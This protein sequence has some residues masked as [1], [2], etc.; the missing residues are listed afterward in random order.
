M[1][2]EAH[3]IFVSYASPDR[4]RVLPI[5]DWLEQQ[6]LN[7]WMDAKRLMPGQNWDF[8][9]NRA[10]D[11]SCIILIFISSNSIDRRGY[12][13]KE[14]RAALDKAKEKLIDDIYI[15]PIIIDIDLD[16]PEQLRHIQCIRISE[17]DYKNV[18]YKS[19]RY[20]LDRLGIKIE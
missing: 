10:L 17:S 13:Q 9:I 18:I 15:I 7:I 16:I 3:L 20:Q 8:E 1:G 5:A 4:H 14:L 19:I 12:I 6:G 2:K 11:K